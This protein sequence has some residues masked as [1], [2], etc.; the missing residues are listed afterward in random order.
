MSSPDD[1]MNNF[2]NILNSPFN[3]QSDS[4]S[5][6]SKKKNINRFGRVPSSILSFSNSIPIK[7]VKSD[8][9]YVS[10]S[11]EE[12]YIVNNVFDER[13]S[14]SWDN[15]MINPSRQYSGTS[16][17]DF[18]ETKWRKD[19]KKSKKHID[20]ADVECILCFRLLYQPVTT[21]CGNYSFFFII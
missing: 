18:I 14:K 10:T 9:K 17:D 12:D 19:E 11:L 6:T 7:T 21:I 8:K 13:C 16:T 1:H 20:I 2:S 15:S 5:I 3:T 4:N